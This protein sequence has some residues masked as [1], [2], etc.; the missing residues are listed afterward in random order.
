MLGT[1]SAYHTRWP[2]TSHHI[3]L[4]IFHGSQVSFQSSLSNKT[5]LSLTDLDAGSLVL[6]LNT[7]KAI[8]GTCSTKPNYFVLDIL[9]S[10]YKSSS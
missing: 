7:N 2:H 5:D 1:H 4:G 6:L 10:K 9:F 3:A 8:V